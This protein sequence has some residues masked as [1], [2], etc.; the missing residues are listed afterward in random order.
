MDKH[1][2]ENSFAVAS[3]NIENF[4]DIINELEAKI[5]KEK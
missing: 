5:E 3:L 2:L 4:Q 1:L